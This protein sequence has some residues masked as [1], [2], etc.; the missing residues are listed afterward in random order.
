VTIALAALS[1]P[2]HSSALPPEATAQLK[3]L[4]QALGC[5][6]GDTRGLRI[7]C[8]ALRRSTAPMSPGTGVFFGMSVTLPEKADP[9]TAVLKSLHAS[10][11]LFSGDGARAVIQTIK[12]TEP[13]EKEMLLSSLSKV[14]D[15]LRSRIP[16]FKLPKKLGAYLLQR[17]REARHSVKKNKDEWLIRGASTAYLRFVWPRA[18]IV[19]E[20][21]KAGGG[22]FL[23]LF[24]DRAYAS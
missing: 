19:V 9:K 1:V 14:T 20:V 21:P 12:P 3:H 4:G 11:L 18:F 5:S 2:R 22:I 15:V 17:Q 23:S 6:K 7:W 16:N 13:G 24:T 8:L 10:A